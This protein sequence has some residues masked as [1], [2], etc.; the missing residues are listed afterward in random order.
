MA[1]SLLA[2]TIDFTG[3]RVERS[4]RRRGSV[5]LVVVRHGLAAAFLHREARLCTVK[6]LDLTLLID[7]QHQRMFGRIQVQTDDVFAFVD[8]V[9]IAA[10]FETLYAMRFEPMPAPDAPHAGL[11]DA[12]F[13]RHGARRSMRSMEQSGLRGL[14]DHVLDG[15]GGNRR[16]AP[17]PGRIFQQTLDAEREKPLATQSRHAHADFEFGGN[18]EILQCLRSEQ[19]DAAMQGNALPNRT[20]ACKPPKLLAG[21]FVEHD[22]PGNTD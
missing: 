22:G 13:A 20:P 5:A 17:M 15:G 8:E 18:L 16:R 2:Q 9:G 3:G 12:L 14:A 7:L 10:D 21:C 19:D 1:M 6:R 11:R 4:K